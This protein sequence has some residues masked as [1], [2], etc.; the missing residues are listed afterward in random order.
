MQRRVRQ[1]RVCTG[2]RGKGRSRWLD[3]S[4]AGN[5]GRSIKHGGHACCQERAQFFPA[6]R[7][8]IGFGF[9]G[10]CFPNCLGGGLDAVAGSNCLLDARRSAAI[11]EQRSL[12]TRC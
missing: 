2:K 9:G 3:A 1:R 7:S 8:L 12:S 10:S 4:F 11:D 5:R 6:I